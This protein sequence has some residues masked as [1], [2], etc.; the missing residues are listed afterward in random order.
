M[1]ASHLSRIKIQLLGNFVEVYFQR[2]SRLRRAVASLWPAGRLVGENPGALEFVAR[3]LV[4]DRL[5]RAR[6]EGAG[7]S[8]TSIGAAIEKR[9]EVHGGDG[10]IF[11]HPGLNLHQHRM[12]AA[13]TIENLFAG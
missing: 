3:H 8:V 5:Q 12:A 11:F 7:D 13:M 6:V 1:R 2:I 9:F 10:A 4:S